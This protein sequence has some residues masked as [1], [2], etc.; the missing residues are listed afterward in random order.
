MSLSVRIRQLIES[1]NVTPYEISAKTGISQST[2]S[3]ILNDDTAKPNIRNTDL[4]ALYFNVSRD[5]LLTGKEDNLQNASAKDNLDFMKVPIVPVRGKAGYLTGYGDQEYIEALPTMPVIIDK[6]YKG[7]YRCFEVEGDSMD[8]GTR[9]SIYD[10]D[11]VLGREVK[12]ELWRCKL[13]INAWNFIIVHKEG[14]TIKRIVE[15]DVENGT[16]KCHSL[17]SLYEDFTLQLDNVVELYNLIKTV[18]RVERL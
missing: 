8:N 11:I 18:D 15:H 3:R 2:L 4:L 13:H 5:W 16:I 9:G 6:T 17:N 1:K 7:K 10:K 12:R 14:I